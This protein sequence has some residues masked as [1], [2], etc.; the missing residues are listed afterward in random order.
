M[1]R[2][3]GNVNA[4]AVVVA[5]ELNV[6]RFTLADEKALLEHKNLEL[7]GHEL[8][9]SAFKDAKVLTADVHSVYSRVWNPPFRDIATNV[10][11]CASDDAVK[12]GGSGITREV[13]AL[14]KLW[15]SKH[16]VVGHA[17][18]PKLHESLN[19]KKTPPPGGCNSLR[20][21]S[22][23]AAACW[24]TCILARPHVPVPRAFA[25]LL[26]HFVGK[27]GPAHEQ[28]SQGVVIVHFVS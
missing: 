27:S 5:E 18:V 22:V 3:N 9:Q 6:P 15:Q 25:A 23:C 17:E 10:L 13:A 26:H 4:G 8:A 7:P 21:R 1:P 12:V 2:S 14:V 28:Y 19:Q 11:S 24:C 20:H 16:N